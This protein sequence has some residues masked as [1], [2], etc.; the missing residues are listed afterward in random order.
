MDVIICSSRGKKMRRRLRFLHP[1][2]RKLIVYAA[3]GLKLEQIRDW[4]QA[5]L[6][7]HIPAHELP[8][9]HVY[10]LAGI[11]DVTYRDFDR[12]Y[13]RGVKYDE[14]IFNESPEQAFSRVSTIITE[15]SDKIAQVGAV[16]CFST[17]VPCSLDTWNTMRLED[18]KTAFLLHHPHYASM[19]ANMI[20]AIDQ[21]N[22]FIVGLNSI[23]HM[24]T[25][26]LAS[27]IKTNKGK[28]RTPRVHYSRLVDGVHP[29]YDLSDLWADKIVKTMRD[30]R[31]TVTC[32][33]R[34]ASSDSSEDLLHEELLRSISIS[35][36]AE[37]AA[38]GLPNLGLGQHYVL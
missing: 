20:K 2:S 38:E 15:L 35:L 12:C 28:N 27:T 32:R 18:H 37:L 7:Y 30:N 1:N 31:Y 17:I 13:R 3:S 21:I 14:V 11:C 36:D 34:V 24:N 6:K 5:Y 8:K 19:Q 23:H 22:R 9:C 10:L 29:S 33:Q 25:P 4:I 16:P 26:L